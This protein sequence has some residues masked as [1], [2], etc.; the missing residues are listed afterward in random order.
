[1]NVSLPLFSE[2]GSISDIS[3]LATICFQLAKHPEKY[4]KLKQEVLGAK[5][6]FEDLQSLPYL[7]GVIKEGLRISMANP[8]RLPRVVPEAGWTFKGVYL[9]HRTEVSCA[10]FELHFNEGVFEDPREFMP[11]RWLDA[12]ESMKRDSIPFGLGPRQCIAR[13][14]GKP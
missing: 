12:S 10:P 6:T 11:E 14:L 2:H 9:P 1:M 7:Q 5:P 13:N 8:S 4:E 3:Q